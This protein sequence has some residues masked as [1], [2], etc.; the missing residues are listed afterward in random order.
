M[1]TTEAEAWAAIG[2]S[3]KRL[4]ASHFEFRRQ[5]KKLVLRAKLV[6]PGLRW[7]LCS[8]WG[9]TDEQA[10]KTLAWWLREAEA[11]QRKWR[12]GHGDG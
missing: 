3:L 6:C 2:E 12:S 11:S 1:A 5:P 8:P 7:T 4:G 10:T 9:G